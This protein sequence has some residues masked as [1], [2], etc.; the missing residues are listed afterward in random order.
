[1]EDKNFWKVTIQGHLGNKILE[2]QRTATK[3][4]SEHNSN[5]EQFGKFFSENIMIFEN[6]QRISHYMV[7]WL[8]PNLIPTKFLAIWYPA[9][10]Y[11]LMYLVIVTTKPPHIMERME[12]SDPSVT[13]DEILMSDKAK[14]M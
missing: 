1:M 11:I 13:L 14:S 10:I 8:N 7:F 2:I 5:I 9:V 4:K 3:A 6:F 12:S